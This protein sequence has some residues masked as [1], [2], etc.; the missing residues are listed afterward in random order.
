MKL[1]LQQLLELDVC[2]GQCL[3][4]A[5]HFG[6]E[7]E[8]T[9]ELCEKFAGVFHWDWAAQN[10]L[11]DTARAKYIRAVAP[12]RAEYHRAVVPAPALA[13]Y[14][15]VKAATFARWYNTQAYGLS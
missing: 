3:L 9:E 1:T 11:K 8:V 5:E 14:S 13:E 7:V 4:F 15:R 2:E 10:L 12:A 6:K